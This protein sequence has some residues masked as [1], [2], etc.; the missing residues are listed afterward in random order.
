MVIAIVEG[1]K[2]DVSRGMTKAYEMLEMAVQLSPNNGTYYINSNGTEEKVSYAKQKRLALGILAS[3]QK[4]GVKQGDYIM[5]DVASSKVYHLLMWA[6]FYGGFVLTTLPRPDF[7]DEKSQTVK[8]M[9]DI[10]QMLNCPVM[11]TDDVVCAVYK[12]VMHTNKVYIMDDL[13]SDNTGKI[14]SISSK[15]AAY[16]Q[17]SSGSTGNR[18]GAILSNENLI[19]E[20]CDL[21]D[22]ENFK[23]DERLLTWLPH[24]HN[25]GAF[26][27]TFTSAVLGCNSW[28]MSTELFARNPSLFLE[29]VS[30]HR[31]TRLCINN[32]GLQMLLKYA[33]QFPDSSYDLTGLR[34]IYIGAENPSYQL[35][36]DF[37][38]AYGVDESVFKPG[39]GMSETVVAV[40]CSHTGFSKGDILLAS[41]KE[42]IEK[43]KV[44]LYSGKDENNQ[45]ALIEHGYPLTN[46]SIGI[47]SE[48][49]LPLEE[50]M[51][52]SIRIKGDI[53]FQGYCNPDDNVGVFCNGWYITGDLGFIRDRKLYIVGRTKDIIIVN[54]VN[55]ML[56]DMENVIERKMKAAPKLLFISVDDQAN[57]SLV[58]FIEMPQY[59]AEEYHK[60]AA[61]IRNFLRCDY[62]IDV[63]NIVPIEK[64]KRNASRKVDRYGMKISY[65][66]GEFDGVIESLKKT[67]YQEKT[68]PQLIDE[69]K[70][71]QAITECWKQV[72]EIQEK[73]ISLDKSYKRLGG[74]SVRGYFLIQKIEEKLEELG[75]DNISLSQDIFLKCSTIREMSDYI[76]SLKPI[77]A[78]DDISYSEDEIAITGLAFRL[79]DAQNQ[80][81]LWDVLINGR[82]CVKMAGSERQSL[83]KNRVWNDIFGQIEDIDCFDYNFFNLSKEAASYMDPQQRLSLEVAYNALD[84]AGEGVL[85]EENKDIAVISAA[86]GN[87][88][89]P[90]VLDHIKSTGAD[91]LPETAMIDNLNSTIATRIAK[92]LNSNGVAMSIDSACSSFMVALST[93]ERLV[94]NGESK[95]A[96]VIGTNILPSSYTH[97]LAQKAGILSSGNATKV[98]AKDADGSLLGEGVVAVYLEGVNQ[99]VQNRKHIYGVIAGSAMNNDGAALSIMAPN[100]SGQYDVMKKAYEQSGVNSKRISYIEAHGAGTKIG[101]PIELTSLKAMFGTGRSEREKIIIGSAKSNFGHTL[102]C[103][104]GVGLI[105][106]LMCM[107]NDTLVPVLNVE[108][109]NPLLEDSDFPFELLTAPR[110][111]PR[112]EAEPRYAGINSFGIGGTNA[113]VIIKDGPKMQG[114]DSNKNNYHVVVCSAK[115]KED[116]PIVKDNIMTAI[117]DD[118]N[119]TD[120]CYTLSHSRNHYKYRCSFIMSN[121][122]VLCGDISQ[123]EQTRISG[124]RVAVVCDNSIID[125]KLRILLNEQLNKVTDGQCFFADTPEIFKADYVLAINLSEASIA[126]LKITNESIKAVKKLYLSPQE[127]NEEYLMACLLR[128]IY[129]CGATIIWDELWKGK[130]GNIVNNL[131]AYPFKKSKVWL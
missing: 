122:K 72:L 92:Y 39:Y 99:A 96:L 102:A 65:L 70:L 40:C 74:N 95:G 98:F 88:Y 91:N 94:K 67:D 10:W 118:V 84:D 127:V 11:I 105:K 129:T 29:K 18:K 4:I 114:N 38:V 100:P 131:P 81:E 9:L 2:K 126:S 90:M 51:I 23:K 27:F 12:K 30:M 44:V 54:G 73:T 77:I 24:T 64:I 128:E 43:R 8:G 26:T 66:N 101:D 124:N 69:D 46:V 19:S 115:R 6:C 68:I 108:E 37:A 76:S 93:A 34:V 15:D 45:M 36:N 60:I 110:N 80:E 21:I 63:K 87:L 35:M 104:G 116:L 120:L 48:D 20:C 61:E 32:L 107:K 28:Y 33:E 71:V 117:K 103:A 121:N 7:Y 3:L 79:P 16:I 57:E 25:F 130:L 85:A 86:S 49:N 89:L 31:V 112:S 75:Y 113:H 78:E 83:S 52:G 17:F 97:L 13:Y 58:A 111:W 14:A 47:F 82:E 62:G 106:V 41:R 22:Y 5:V 1:D 109:K 50:N 42:L 125:E 59:S 123:G 119:M 53:V 55:Y 56:T